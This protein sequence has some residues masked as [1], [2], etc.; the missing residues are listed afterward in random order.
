MIIRT[1]ENHFTLGLKH[2][3]N[4]KDI[5]Y[6]CQ[7]FLLLVLNRIC[8]YSFHSYIFEE[9]GENSYQSPFDEN[10]GYAILFS[11]VQ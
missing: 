7:I 5:F 9:M 10:W 8:I 1:I 4:T 11:L 3:F 6:F 2:A